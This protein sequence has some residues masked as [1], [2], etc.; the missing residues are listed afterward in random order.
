MFSANEN[1][2]LR[3]HKRRIV[4][5]I[6]T[7][8]PEDAL[9]LGTTVMV[10]QT[11]CNAPGCVP[12]ETNIIIVFPRSIKELVSGLKESRQG[13]SFKTKI[14]KPMADVTDIDVLEALPPCFEG[15]QR[16]MEKLCIRARDVM[17]AQ[18]TQLFGEEADE[19]VDDRR[20][21]AIYLQQCLQDY[22]QAGCVPPKLGEPCPRHVESDG[23]SIKEGSDDSRPAECHSK[24]DGITDCEIKRD[25][26]TEPQQTMPI[27]G[28]GNIIIQRGPNHDSGNESATTI[29]KPN[30]AVTTTTSLRGLSFNSKQQTSILQYQSSNNASIARLFDRE[31]APGIRQAGCPCCDPENPSSLMDTFMM[32]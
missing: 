32:L 9:D 25:A 11:S 22:V 24:A 23:D 5:R 26:R 28:T 17:I 8:I 27:P 20:A 10:M 18:I 29:T 7:M 4:Q 6:E 3:Q 15:G 2:A 12:L 1:L 16:S 21:M 19:T 30:M 13:G 31:H 14:L